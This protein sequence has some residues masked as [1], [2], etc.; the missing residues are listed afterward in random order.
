[1]TPQNAAAGLHLRFDGLVS[2]IARDPESLRLDGGRARE[3]ATYQEVT[4]VA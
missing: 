1:M 2:K 4:D 3:H